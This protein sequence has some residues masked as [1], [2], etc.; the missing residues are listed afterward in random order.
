M[1]KPALPTSPIPNRTTPA[2]PSYPPPKYS[3]FDVRFEKLKYWVEV[4]D[5]YP[6]S[7][8]LQ[9]IQ[10]EVRNKRDRDFLYDHIEYKQNEY[11]AN[12]PSNNDNNEATPKVQVAVLKT[13]DTLKKE[14]RDLIKSYKQKSKKIVDAVLN[15]L[16][17]M[18]KNHEHKKMVKKMLNK[19]QTTH[20]EKLNNLHD[21]VIP[22]L[23]SIISDVRSMTTT[24]G[25]CNDIV[26]QFRKARTN[27]R[28]RLR[29][30]LLYYKTHNYD[31]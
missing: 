27:V 12:P 26:E 29:N 16:H 5:K 10:Y 31:Y 28:T 15:P 30:N 9:D 13:P 4:I 19:W 20:N 11:D 21:E 22:I 14:A 6:Y 25:E 23:K 7:S 17:G 2:M 24:P 18:K 1:T 3:P 8:L